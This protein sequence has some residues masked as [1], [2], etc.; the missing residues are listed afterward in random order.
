MTNAVLAVVTLCLCPAVFAASV[1]NMRLEDPKAV[2]LDAPATTGDSSAALQ[3]FG[4]EPMRFDIV[5]T[6]ETMP[7]LTGIDLARKI[8]SVR[9]DIPI[10]LMSGYGGTRLAQSAHA[11]GINDI[12][13]KPLQSRDIAQ[14][15]A[16]AISASH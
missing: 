16:R 1:I 15:L 2:Y 4:A 3:A 11:A 6:D 9:P 14:S 5:L 12:L 7:G 8:H 10:I 13:H